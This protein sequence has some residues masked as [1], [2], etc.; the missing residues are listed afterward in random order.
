[1]ATTITV[2]T[3]GYHTFQIWMR[4]DGNIVDK[5]MLSTNSGDKPGNGDDTGPVESD[6]ESEA[7]TTYT[8]TVT[9]GSGDGEYEE[10]TIV[11]ITADAPGSG[12]IFDQWTG[13]TGYVANVLSSTTSVTM[14]AANISLTATYVNVYTLT[15]SSGT[16]GGVYEQNDVVEIVA[17]QPEEGQEF[18]QWTGDTAYVTNVNSS[19]TNVT[20]PAANVTV[21]ATYADILYAL[22]VTS[23]TGD[24]S[25]AMGSV[26]E[27]VADS[28]GG[29]QIFKEWTGDTDALADPNASTTNVY[30]PAEDVSI[31]ATYDTYYT[32]TVTSGTGDGS[33]LLGAVVNISADDPASGYEFDEWT[34][35]VAYVAN[36]NSADTTI[37]MPASNISVTAT[38][39]AIPT[40]TLAVNS[41]TGDGTYYASQVVN[42]V[43]D[44]P[45]SG[46]VFSKWTGDTANVAN[47]NASSTNITMPAANA[48]VTATYVSA[49]G[50]AFIETGGMAVMEAENYTSEAGGTGVAAACTWDEVYTVSGD[51]GDSMQA[52]PNTGVNPGDGSTIG[53]RMDYKVNFNTTGV[54]YLFVRMPARDGGDNSVNYGLDN[55]LAGSNLNSTAGEWRWPKGA[56]GITVSSTGYHTLNIWMREDGMIVDKVILTTNASYYL[57]GTDLGPAE[58][59]RESAATY[60]LTVNSGSGDGDYAEDYVAAISADAPATGKQFDQWTGDVAYVTNVNSSS[61]TVTMPAQNVTVTATYAE[62]DYTLTV[63]SGTGDG[64]YNYQDVATIDADTPASGYVFNKWTGDTATVN[65][66]Y[67]SHT[68]ITMPAANASV[69][70]TYKQLYVLTVNNGSGDGSYEEDAVVQIVADAPLANYHF[71]AWTG[72]TAYVANVNSSTTTVT[73]P[74]QAVT[75]TATYEEDP[76]Y[77]LTVTS[78]SGDGSY[79]EDAVVNISADAPQ[80]GYVFT[81]WTGDTAYVASPSQAS[82]NVTM[83]A[84]NITVTATYAEETS[85]TLTVNSGTGDGDYAEDAVVD[86][87]A[88]APDT[89]YVFDEWT[90]DVAYVANVNSESTTVTMPASNVTVTATYVAT[91]GAFQ[92]GSGM[93]VFEA[94]NYT[95]KQAGTGAGSATYW[96][97]ST[98]TSGASGGEVMVA[99]PDNNDPR[100]NLN[101]TEGCRLDF[102]CN[103]ST[104]GVYYIHVRMPALAT[105]DDTIH[106]GL[107]GTKTNH[108]LTN[109]SG[110]WKWVYEDSV[111]VATTTVTSTGEHTFNI[112]MRENGVR[113]DKVVLTTNS[114]YTPTGEG[115][116]E[117]DFE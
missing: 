77:T 69:T 12:Q 73:M 59:E 108:I 82:T 38:Y 76:K 37:T 24:G 105:T 51:S 66:I 56:A 75:V 44:A 99:C 16:G 48:T 107:D 72:N 20:M 25:Y 68:T 23:G 60:S 47:V 42:I 85:Y 65:N 19:T 8:L 3:T 93:V 88:D 57:A 114:S 2:S 27:V 106:A 39:S 87:N 40:Y 100:I 78:G 90:G 50:D 46:Y 43:A 62:I 6:R 30:M 79:Y 89:G 5:I 109:S 80:Q 17:N 41:G 21:T 64:T 98:S 81:G 91:S 26:V 111:G 70:A 31:T 45:A 95:D 110:A 13:D 52:L 15:V 115:P 49:S 28:P 61:T 33:Y 34:G 9:S 84:S 116:A 32:L 35:D 103:F 22:T 4:E 29:G 86:I 83:P 54:Y 71:D 7:P 104:T 58:S 10:S 67:A 63:T 18:D 14:P 97:V 53:P 1:V 55:S 11:G 36:V 92:E 94:E 113:V 101:T 74:A 102:D 96:D 112:W 117:S